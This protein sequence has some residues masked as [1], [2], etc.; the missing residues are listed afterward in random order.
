[1]GCTHALCDLVGFSHFI[2]GLSG[3]FNGLLREVDLYPQAN[4][5]DNGDQSTPFRPVHRSPLGAEIALAILGS[6]P[7]WL[8]VK[9]GLDRFL[10]NRVDSWRGLLDLAGAAVIWAAIVGVWAWWGN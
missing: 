1:L 4:R 10:S 6:I 5:A 7:A 8:F 2:S 3:V 9:R